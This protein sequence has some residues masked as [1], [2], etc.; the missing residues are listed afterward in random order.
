MSALVQ[1]LRSPAAVRWGGGGGHGASAAAS[2]ADAG[3]HGEHAQS[4]QAAAYD[5]EVPRLFGEP[6]RVLGGVARRGQPRGAGARA[7]LPPPPSISPPLPPAAATSPPQAL[8]P[9]ASRPREDWEGSFFFMLAGTALVV[10]LGSLKPNANVRDWARDEA[11][12]RVRREKA[13]LEVVPG[14]NYAGIRMLKEAGALAED[15]AA[16]LEAGAIPAPPRLS[17][18]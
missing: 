1:G 14:V 11:S 16:A 17:M 9:G 7:G 3:H 4:A 5:A 12:E 15:E 10:A 13:G 8:A 2:H 18:A 6:V